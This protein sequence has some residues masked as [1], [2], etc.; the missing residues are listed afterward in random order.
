MVR[1][2]GTRF[3]SAGREVELIDKDPD[4]ARALAEELGGSTRAVDAINGEI[5]V[6]ALPYEGIASAVEQFRD[7]LAGG[8]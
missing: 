8:S 5:V 7:S 6:L 4:A 1:G 3:L 2:I